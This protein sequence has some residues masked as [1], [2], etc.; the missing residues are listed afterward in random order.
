MPLEELDPKFCAGY[1]STQQVE[2]AI[3]ENDFTA[4]YTQR[5][6]DGVNNVRDTWNI[7]FPE[8]T[9]ADMSELWEFLNS[10]KGYKAFLWVPPRESKIRQWLCQKLQRSAVSSNSWTIEATF[11]EQFTHYTGEAINHRFSGI[12]AVA[13]AGQMTTERA[14]APGTAGVSGIGAT[15]I[16]NS[17]FPSQFIQE[18]FSYND[19]KTY[20]DMII[21]D[22]YMYA[23]Y[24][25]KH[26]AKIHVASFKPVDLFDIDLMSGLGLDTQIRFWKRTLAADSNYLYVISHQSTKILRISLS[27]FRT[28]AIKNITPYGLF[29]AIFVYGGY[30]WCLPGDSG[31]P[32][33][34]R[35]LLSDFN[36]VEVLDYSSLQIT[37]SLLRY[38]QGFA[39][40][41]QYCTC[42]MGRHNVRFGGAQES[43]TRSIRFDLNNF[44]LG[45]ITLLN[46]PTTFSSDF[47]YCNRG[48]YDGGNWIYFIS[49]QR[50]ALLRI[51]TTH[52]A[53]EAYDFN[54]L[55]TPRGQ[56][57]GYPS[58]VQIVGN[59]LYALGYW[60]N[61]M[62][63]IDL[64]SSGTIAGMTKIFIDAVAYALGDNPDGRR[65]YVEFFDIYTD[66]QWIYC[67]VNTTNSNVNTTFTKNNIPG[68]IRVLASQGPYFPSPTNATDF[69]YG[70][71]ND[72]W[73]GDDFSYNLP[74]A[75]SIFSYQNHLWEGTLTAN[76]RVYVLAIAMQFGDGS[77][78]GSILSVTLGGT[79]CIKAVDIS[80]GENYAGIWY[81]VSGTGG[82][83][84]DIVANQAVHYY[85]VD[86]FSVDGVASLK[87]SSF[88]TVSGTGHAAT[89]TYDTDQDGTVIG[90]VAVG[91]IPTDWDINF[92]DPYPAFDYWNWDYWG[93]EDPDWLNSLFLFQFVRDGNNNHPAITGGTVT[94]DWKDYSFPEAITEDYP[95][96][97][98]IASFN[99]GIVLTEV[100]K[101][102]TGVI[103]QGGVGIII[104]PV[105]I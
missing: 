81:V 27:D 78:G 5:D 64:S 79:P 67:I 21:Q 56:F 52:T 57:L 98:C 6:R 47:T 1:A 34:V 10:R 88:S 43:D 48:A 61:A 41:G 22:D 14:F 68:I 103:C 19:L 59:Q 105:F 46:M 44:T 30:L 20:T 91:G 93:P 73:A 29:H 100:N 95:W 97:A 82:K 38:T 99:K 104:N 45:G 84:L 4:G 63:K 85:E 62:I 70:V 23:F 87:P 3:K 15:G 11:Q 75:T 26:I 16:A 58:G 32:K 33:L 90:V 83:D 49:Q 24:G 71:D 7:T 13:T 86:T 31:I 51:N 72:F 9:Y 17:I 54:Q 25:Y 60:D 94:A 12:R 96:V 39:V 92:S 66:G 77:S 50:G 42:T 2:F 80:V 102:V 35:L 37:G 18:Y 40:W 101:Y 8:L 55:T 69:Q 65:Q 89:F 28:T 74:A 53:Y 76:H 36:T